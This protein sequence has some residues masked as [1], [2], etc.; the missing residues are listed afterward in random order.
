M[1]RSRSRSPISR[2]SRRREEEDN[3]AG[4][5][6]RYDDRGPARGD[7][8]QRRHS[9]RYN[10]AGDDRDRRY[11]P[12][13][14]RNEPER[15][16]RR[17]IDRNRNDSQ[18][19]QDD[20][21]ERDGRRDRPCER[22]V[23]ESGIERYGG[24]SGGPP[25][26][27]RKSPEE[28]VDK[29]KPNF[30]NSGLLAAATNTVKHSDGGATVL[31]YNEPPEARKPSQGW[32]LYVFK[33]KEDAGVLHIEKQSAYL[34]GRDHIVADIP[35]DHPSCSKQHAV[36]QFRQVQEKNEYG[37]A[38]AVVKPFII[39]LEST[40]G[41]HVNDDTI[42]VSRY[43]ELKPS[44]VIKFGQSVREYVLLNEDA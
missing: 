33:G 3:Q 42:P 28:E 37:D 40:N 32:R 38:K 22:D 17:D 6:R 21:H 25:P 35:I 1:P 12:R 26:L 7:E 27:G 29:M 43:Y 11:G 4:N 44:D 23:D 24:S 18:R 5:R 36:I 39:D 31:K 13:R 19:R 8:R 14:T 2:S 16:P 15:Y 9:P 30:A 10:D 34:I 20:R 41:T